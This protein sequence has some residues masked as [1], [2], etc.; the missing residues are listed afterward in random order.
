VVSLRE[1]KKAVLIADLKARTS[2]MPLLLD[3]SDFVLHVDRTIRVL[4]ERLFN[5]RS[6]VFTDAANG[7][8]DVTALRIDEINAVYFSADSS[9]SLLGGLDLGVG[10]MPIISSQM[11]PISSLD[12]MVDYLILKNVINS[13]RRKMVNTDDYTLLPLTADGRQILQVRNPGKLF[14]CEFL[15]YIQPEDDS[16]ALFENEYSF[17]FELAFRYICHAN[18]EAQ[19]QASLL[20]VSKEVMTLV[21]YWDT[22]I[23]ELVKAFD[24]SSLIN[25]IG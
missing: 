8:V 21:Q 11:M 1:R 20:G 13:M 6:I 5:P 10:I 12:S 19:V 15:P 2:K 22:Q 4:D 25:Y 23:K 14:W 3:D 7:Q 18:A 16:W 9:E 17:V 24:E